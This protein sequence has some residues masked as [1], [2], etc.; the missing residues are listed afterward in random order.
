MTDSSAL[1]PSYEQL[2]M[3]ADAHAL[4]ASV[5]FHAD[6]D[7]KVEV[8]RIFEEFS[9]TYQPLL[10]DRPYAALFKTYHSLVLTSLTNLLTGQCSPPP[11]PVKVSEI[12]DSDLIYRANR[13][14]AN[15]ELWNDYVISTNAL[16]EHLAKEMATA[17]SKGSDTEALL[18]QHN[19]QYVAL[20][21]SFGISDKEQEREP[22]L[23]RDSY[24]S[25]LNAEISRLTS[26]AP[27]QDMSLEA[28]LNLNK[29]RHHGITR[30]GAIVN[31]P[32][33]DEF[34]PIPEK[35]YE[36]IASIVLSGGAILAVSRLRQAFPDMQVSRAREL[37]SS[38]YQYQQALGLR[39]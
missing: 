17:I 8:D 26:Q 30:S 14:G 16:A 1:I 6:G 27:Q 28:E 23:F 24:S 33:G 4:E 36:E 5:A 29:M 19:L 32:I 9:E 34:V 11:S 38:I 10:A 18:Q 39:Q 2:K 22:N 3:M 12:I 31:I 37:T 20:W 21:H 25:H 15:D 13:L 7:G 35:I